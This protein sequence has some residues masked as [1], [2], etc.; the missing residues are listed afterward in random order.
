MSVWRKSM[1]TNEDGRRESM[2][3]HS[4]IVSVSLCVG[5]GSVLVM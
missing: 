2:A 4:C 1:N 3:H 5:I